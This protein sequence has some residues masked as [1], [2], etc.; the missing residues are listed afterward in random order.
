MLEADH[1]LVARIAQ[2]AAMPTDGLTRK[3]LAIE[4]RPDEE[5]ITDPAAIAAILGL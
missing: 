4:D 3:A 1:N 2:S 5:S